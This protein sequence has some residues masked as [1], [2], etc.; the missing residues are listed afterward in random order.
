MSPLHQALRDYLGI[1]RR[2]GFQLTKDGRMLEGFVGF[3]EESGA[4]R[5]TS[6]LALAWAR[7]PGEIHPYHCW[8]RLS[9]VRSFARYLAAIDPD[10][11]VPP[12]D[13]LP[14]RYS[15]ITPYIYSPAEIA[16]LMAA[17]RA[18]TPPLRAA[19][20]ETVIGLLAVSGMRIGET[21]ALDRA[22]VDLDDG[23][24]HV[25]TGKQQRQREVPLHESATEALRRYAR[26]RD[27][28]RPR[29]ATPAFFLDARG[30]RVMIWSFER[31]FREIIQQTGLEGRGARCR[32]RPHDVRHTFAV[33]TLLG[34]YRDGVDVD[35]KMPLL[36]SYLGHADATHTYW[37]LQAAPE[38]LELV[39]ERLDQLQEALS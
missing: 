36:S 20:I 3:L 33:R 38:L 8:Q 10:S 30:G 37:Y 1:R 4:E 19:G 15:R 28:H 24:L 21:L 13:L 18:L 27:R 32:P 26:L 7:R 35:R 6:E 16:A 2:L 22:D 11:E 14:A 9:I 17:A 5:I 34:W 23:V 29:P 25:R 12:E 39:S 31:S